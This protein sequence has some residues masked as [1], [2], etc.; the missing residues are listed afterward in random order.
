MKTYSIDLRQ[1]IIDAYD[2]GGRT[3]KE[4]AERFDVSEGMVKKLLAQRKSIGTIEPLY[5]N[6][7]R[8]PLFT[9][10]TLKQL[11]EYVQTHSDATLEQIQAHFSDKVSCTLV[12]IH[13]TLKRLKYRYKKNGTRQ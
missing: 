4:V 1:R 12:T 10:E 6:S 2:A 13:N 8:K 9:G 11:D 7:G 5:H 3:R